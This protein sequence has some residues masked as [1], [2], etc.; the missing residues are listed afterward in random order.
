MTILTQRRSDGSL[1]L[2]GRIGRSLGL[3]RLLY[4]CYY[5]PLWRLRRRRVPDRPVEVPL[6]GL[7]FH[8]PSPRRF[9]CFRGIYLDGVW[10]PAVTRAVRD[11]VRP[12]MNVALIGADVGYY[13]LLV[14]SL[15]RTGRIL[16]VEPFPAHFAILERNVRDN[17]L[18]NVKLFNI[19][20]GR[21]ERTAELVNPGTESRL[22]LD[23]GTT[24]TGERITVPVRPLATVLT[25]EIPPGQ[26]LDLVEI[27]IEG[28][29]WDALLG[30][31]PL[32]LRDRPTIL[33]EL[34]GPLLPNFGTTKADFL[35]W[36]A[37][38][39]YSVR[40]VDGEALEEP[41]YSHVLFTAR[42][43]DRS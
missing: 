35:R 18:D 17:R 32:L 10:E 34:H 5:R 1:T 2:L 33:V 6:F 38:R 7:R 42:P 11:I 43:P 12:G 27:D 40:W 25:P 21:D 4:H 30:L 36:M 23:G 9:D 37:D 8:M 24:S 19:A 3:G 14:A 29:E 41:G 15:N 13:V 39:G 20:A 28:A 26:K 16:A 22:D 31:E